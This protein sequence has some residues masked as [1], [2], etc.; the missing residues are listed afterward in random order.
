MVNVKKR[1]GKKSLHISGLISGLFFFAKAKK[2]YFWG[3]FGYY[4][5]NEIFPKI[6]LRHN[7][8]SKAP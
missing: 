6:W 5:Q 7:F 1:K 4:P 3:V 8:T 2:R